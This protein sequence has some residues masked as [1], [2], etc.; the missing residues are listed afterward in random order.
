MS[1]RYPIEASTYKE[2]GEKHER[3]EMVPLRD[4]RPD[5]PAGF[6][7]VVERALSFDPLR[8]YP[9]AGAMEQALAEYLGLTIAQP[10]KP[11]APRV[12]LIIG[13]QPKLK[14]WAIL[15]AY[16]DS[17]RPKHGAAAAATGGRCCLRKR[18]PRR[19]CTE[20]TDSRELLPGA[21]IFR[22]TSSGN[23][24]LRLDV[25]TC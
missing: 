6:A 11:P 24:R 16:P 2:L 21:K 10:V 17:R 14:G 12:E 22:E 8:R 25:R 15:G 1:G 9:S 19:I 5:V 23:P 4:A 20:G 18:P 7:R 3:R 13:P